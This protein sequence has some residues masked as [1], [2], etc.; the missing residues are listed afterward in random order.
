MKK[1]YVAP[2]AEKVD[3]DYEENVVASG[4]QKQCD[5]NW[6]RPNCGTTYRGGFSFSIDIG[7]IVKGIIDI[8]K[9]W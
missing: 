6:T 9:W 7:K 1:Q 2:M 8:F 3:F 4:P 5:Y